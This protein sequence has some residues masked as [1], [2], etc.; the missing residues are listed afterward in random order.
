[1]AS[2]QPNVAYV[3]RSRRIMLG[4]SQTRLAELVDRTATTIRRWERGEVLPPEDAIGPLA[5]AL[6]V[7]EAQLRPPPSPQRSS[8]VVVGQATPPPPSRTADGDGPPVTAKPI[9]PPPAAQPSRAARPAPARAR[10]PVPA[11]EDTTTDEPG[12]PWI[13]FEEVTPPPPPP[14]SPATPPVPAVA[15]V[16]AAAPAPARSQ[17]PVTPAPDP[18]VTAPVAPP[19]RPVARAVPVV[20]PKSYLEDPK[21]RFLYGL[22][23]IVTIAALGVLAVVAA[24]AFQELFGTVDSALDFFSETTVPGDGL[25][26]P[27]LPGAES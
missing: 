24:W 10:R 17:A 6:D 25:D 4:L 19:R 16:G 7:D 12:K 18:D 5:A 11:A 2:T 9:A 1:M 8:V 21:Q 22:R 15:P 26:L 14:P 23:L 20:Q 13:H 3:I 27:A